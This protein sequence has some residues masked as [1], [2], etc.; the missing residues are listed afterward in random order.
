MPGLV[1][2]VNPLKDVNCVENSS[3][4]AY[5]DNQDEAIV[6]SMKKGG[7]T[8]VFGQASDRDLVIQPGHEYCEQCSSHILQCGFV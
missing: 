5:N 6:F 1:S 2:L 3:T 8:F 4:N 7:K